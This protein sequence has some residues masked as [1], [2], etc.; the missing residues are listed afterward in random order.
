MIHRVHPGLA[1]PGRSRPVRLLRGLVWAVIGACLA[2]FV[3]SLAVPLW[4]G[5]QGQRLLIVTSGSMAP[6]V[7]AGDAVVIQAVTDPSQLRVGQVASFWPPGA[8]HMVTH[9]I[10]DMVMLPAM[11]QNSA[12]GE[13]VPQHDPATGEPVERAFILTKG[14]ANQT[15]DPNATPLTRVRGVVLEA[16]HGWGSRIGWAHSP[17]GRWVMLA[18]PLIL[19][20]LLELVDSWSERRRREPAAAT[21]PDSPEG[22]LDALLLD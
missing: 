7:Q 10:V 22:R 5:A 14:D 20:A 18:P 9:R 4:F 21:G 6:Y 19:L 15:N 13:M 11:I 2:A 8:E 16:H 12:T 1:L 17:T 3:T